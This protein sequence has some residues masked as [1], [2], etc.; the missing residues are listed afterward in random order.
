MVTD[1][2][3]YTEPQCSNLPNDDQFRRLLIPSGQVRGISIKRIHPCNE[4]IVS[5][6]VLPKR[7]LQFTCTLNSLI[8]DMWITSVVPVM[9]WLMPGWVCLVRMSWC[10]FAMH[11]CCEISRHGAEQYTGD[12]AT[13]I[14]GCDLDEAISETAEAVH[15]LIPSWHIGE[16]VACVHIAFQRTRLFSGAPEKQLEH[17]HCCTHLTTRNV[18]MAIQA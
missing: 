12:L 11:I 13:L 3:R 17:R 8:V 10:V 6:K 4:R 5:V 1:K 7:L 18:C 2:L 9:L 14:Y 15:R 16:V